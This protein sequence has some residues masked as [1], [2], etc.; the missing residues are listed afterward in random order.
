MACWAADTALGPRARAGASVG[1]DVVRV[2]LGITNP[3]S[4]SYTDSLVC[5]THGPGA[6]PPVRSPV[7]GSLRIHCTQSVSSRRMP[8]YPVK[9][10]RACYAEVVQTCGSLPSEVQV[11]SGCEKVLLQC[12]LPCLAGL[13]V[14]NARCAA[15]PDLVQPVGGLLPSQ[16]VQH[17]Q[18]PLAGRGGVAGGRHV[19]LPDHASNDAACFYCSHCV[20]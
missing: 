14:T 20:A 11:H 19:P 16:H 5:V 15:G 2:N 7:P 1:Q 3:S 13:R 9:H 12:L 8:Q 10:K 6:Q 17:V 4:P 18:R